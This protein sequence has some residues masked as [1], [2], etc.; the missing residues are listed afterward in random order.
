MKLRPLLFSFVLLFAPRGAKGM[1]LSSWTPIFKGI[2]HAVGTNT[3]SASYPNLNV[4]HAI[5]VDLLDPDIQFFTSPRI[6]NYQ[7]NKRETGGYTVSDFLRRNQLQ[8]AINANLFDPQDYYLSAGTPMD[9]FG[10]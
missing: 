10:L 8:L 2:E 1:V 4:I 6:A 9:I 7:E 5:R 3:P